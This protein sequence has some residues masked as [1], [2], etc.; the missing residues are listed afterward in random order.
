MKDSYAQDRAAR[1]T[2]QTA[3]RVY[4]DFKDVPA[5]ALYYIKCITTGE[6]NRIFFYENGEQIWY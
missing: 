6:Q 4:L 5:G 3:S 1:K 2:W